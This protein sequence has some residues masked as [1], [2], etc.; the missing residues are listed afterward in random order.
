MDSSGYEQSIRRGLHAGM[1]QA[2]KNAK[3]A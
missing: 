1:A 3:R 2:R